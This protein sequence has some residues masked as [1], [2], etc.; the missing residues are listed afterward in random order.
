MRKQP[1]MHGLFLILLN[2]K[3]L[4]FTQGWITYVSAWVPSENF[5]SPK[6]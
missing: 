3:R 1:S 5:I 6:V 2:F 4:E